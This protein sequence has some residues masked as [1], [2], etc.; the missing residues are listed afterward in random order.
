MAPP[1]HPLPGLK[2]AYWQT[3]LGSKLKFH[4]EPKS[5][6]HYVRLPDQDQ[7]A[8]E[9]SH[10]KDWQTNEPTVMMIH[11]LGG[12][13][14][15]GYMVRLAHKLLKAGYRVV[16]INLRGCGSGFGHAKKLYH[17]G[18]SDDILAVLQHHQTL[19]PASSVT[20]VGFSLGGNMALK[21]A[22]ELGDKGSDYLQQVIAVCPPIDLSHCSEMIG[23]PKNHT[24]RRYFMKKLK[25]TVRR[26][27][28]LF[29]DLPPPPKIRR[30]NMHLH[31]FD[32]TYTAPHAGFK[33]AEDYYQQASAINV[34]D[35]IR[36]PCRMLFAL[37]D[38]FIDSSILHQ[39]KL[40]A[41]ME[42]HLT[43]HGGHMG[44]LG[45]PRKPG[46]FRWMDHVLLNWIKHP[47]TLINN[48]SAQQT[49]QT[50][51]HSQTPAAD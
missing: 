8:I 43:E 22:G 45:S 33:N 10:P 42:L 24:F 35:Q 32:D 38:P 5:K 49:P 31:Q 44:F 36:V 51:R 13:H 46:G 37:D 41:H 11:G 50:H 27:H 23:Q 48:E 2:S 30:F 39:K 14:R 15:A 4:R 1:F 18:L 9:V 28:L 25:N 47:P 3:I 34:I 40:P 6:T 26:R 21:L 17:G 19:C 7:L 29:P 16:R 20:L 12:C